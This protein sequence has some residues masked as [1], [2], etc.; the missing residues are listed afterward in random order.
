MIQLSRACV[1]QF[2]AALK[3]VGAGKNQRPIVEVVASHAD[4]R[5]RGVMPDVTIELKLP[6]SSQEESIRIPFEALA[7]FE[8]KSDATVTLVKSPGGMVASW[9]DGRIPQ[10]KSYTL[11]ES[12][13]EQL[14]VPEV[15]WST[16]AV[17]PGLVQ[18]LGHAKQ[19]LATD[20]VRYATDKIQLQGE[21]G[22]INA[23]DGRQALIQSGFA[24]PWKEDLLIPG[25]ELFACRELLPDLPATVA[26]GKNRIAIQVGDW[27]IYLVFDTQGRFPDIGAVVPHLTASAS[28]LRLRQMTPIS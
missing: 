19:C 17:V 21:R 20:N 6:G 8:A 28:T 16:A 4:L 22:T 26:K 7:D 11:A 23:T 13:N 9:D 12:A 14:T 24:F 2:R 10:R 5:L 25:L 27:T 1:R 3:K 15:D 18:A